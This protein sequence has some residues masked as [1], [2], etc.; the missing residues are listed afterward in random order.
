[1]ND[2]ALIDAFNV[3]EELSHN[4]SKLAAYLAWLKCMINE[5]AKIS[6]TLHRENKKGKEARNR[7]DI[8]SVIQILI[9]LETLAT[10]TSANNPRYDTRN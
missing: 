1:M 10:L 4:S 8:L 2:E 5:E 9:P 7:E 6:D 3:W